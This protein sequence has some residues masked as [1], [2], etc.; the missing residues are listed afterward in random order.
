MTAPIFRSSR[1]KS[2]AMA[3][4]S[5]FR[6]FE[7]GVQRILPAMHRYQLVLQFADARAQ[8]LQPLRLHGGLAGIRREAR[9]DR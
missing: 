8:L 7:F 6:F 2:E 4:N 9:N 3:P 5:L 1:R